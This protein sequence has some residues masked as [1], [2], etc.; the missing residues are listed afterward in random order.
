M[1]KKTWCMVVASTTVMTLT[2]GFGSVAYASPLDRA[3]IGNTITSRVSMSPSMSDAE[4][5][6]VLTA[7]ENLPEELKRADPRTTPNYEQRLS[8]AL[9]CMRIGGLPALAGTILLQAS[10]WRCGLEVASVIV[11]YGFP[12]AKVIKWIKSAQKLYGGV[13]GIW[14]AIRSGRA[15]GEIGEEGAQ[16]LEMLLG[17]DGVISACFS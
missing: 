10:W 8:E 16:V 14:R 17:F 2:L 3:S 9:H 13:K 4:L 11:Q 5:A 15:V 6:R 1:S 7:L 12:V